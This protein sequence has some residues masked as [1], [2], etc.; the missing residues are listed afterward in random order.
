MSDPQGVQT[1]GNKGLCLPLSIK[2][3]ENLGNQHR[4]SDLWDLFPLLDEHK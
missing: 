2:D 4:A 3:G 1:N